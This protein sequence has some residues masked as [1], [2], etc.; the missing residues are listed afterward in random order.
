M[1]S[2]DGREAILECAHQAGHVVGGKGGLGH[3]RQ[4][5]RILDLEAVHVFG[6][7]DEHDPFRFAEGAFRL[8]VTGMADERDLVAASVEPVHFVVHFG[9]QGARG[10]HDV[11]VP[12]RRFCS[13]RRRHAVGGKDDKSAIGNVVEFVHEDGAPSLQLGHHVAIVDD[14]SPHIDGR[15]VLLEHA[16]DGLDRALDTGAKRPGPGQK[17]RF[18]S[19]CGRPILDDGRGRPQRPQRPPSALDDSR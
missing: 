1:R 17:H 14:L 11:Q 4:A 16:F 6:M 19:H 10:V 13:H 12:I 3:I 5:L 15:A 8:V 2:D 18:R 7:L 9:D